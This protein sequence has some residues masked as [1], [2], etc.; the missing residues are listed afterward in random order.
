MLCQ[1]LIRSP[2]WFLD[3]RASVCSLSVKTDCISASLGWKGCLCLRRLEVDLGLFPQRLEI[4]KTL[5]RLQEN[6][7]C[8][9]VCGEEDTMCQPSAATGSAAKPDRVT[10]LGFPWATTPGAIL[11]QLKIQI[12][13]GGS[14]GNR[15]YSAAV[16][17]YACHAYKDQNSIPRWKKTNMWHRASW[18]CATSAWFLELHGMCH[19]ER[20]ANYSHSAIRSGDLWIFF[21]S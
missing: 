17:W 3:R 19:K 15:T 12:A 20:R 21:K 13:C 8:N 11:G 10:Y 6:I 1:A 5:A 7:T 4:L 18:G 14:A 9:S 2:L 16:F